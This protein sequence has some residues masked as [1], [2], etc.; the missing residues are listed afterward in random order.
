MSPLRMRM[1]EDMKLAGLSPATQA[2]YIDAVRKLAE[3]YRR[4]PDQLS[5][6]EA[7]ARI[8]AQPSVADRLP[9]V[10]EVIDNSGSLEE[11][12]KQVVAAYERFCTRFPV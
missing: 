12:R 11:T 1:I 2:T 9:L 4:S 10:D 8:L 7:W 6:E 5:E 3:H